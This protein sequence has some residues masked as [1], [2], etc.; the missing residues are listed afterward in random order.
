MCDHENLYVKT[1]DFERWSEKG[2]IAF[3]VNAYNALTLKAVIDNYPIKSSMFRS[4]VYPKNSIR[5]IPGV[6]DKIQ[7]NV[8]GKKVTIGHI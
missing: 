1:K 7:V 3:W 2:K 8:M 4:A 5:Q 6:W